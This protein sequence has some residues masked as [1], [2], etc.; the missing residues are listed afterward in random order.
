MSDRLFIFDT[1]LRD[2]EAGTGMPVEH[3]GKDSGGKAAGSIR[4]GCN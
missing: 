3:S 2:G 4:C 1:T